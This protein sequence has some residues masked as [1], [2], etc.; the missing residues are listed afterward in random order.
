[1]S[2]TRRILYPNETGGISVLIP[3]GEIPFEDVCRKD[4]PAMLPPIIAMC[5]LIGYN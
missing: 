2:E 3:S 4:V 5:I 1:M